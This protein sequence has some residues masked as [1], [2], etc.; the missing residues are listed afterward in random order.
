MPRVFLCDFDGTVAP[1]DIGAAFARAFSPGGLAETPEFLAAWTRGEMGHRELT[2]A[3]C[4]LLDVDRERALAFTRGFGI[5]PDF[6]VFVHAARARGD[7]VTVVSEGFDFY[8]G[9][10]LE[11]AGL[12][13]VSFSANT[14]R[15]DGARV[16]PEFPD[17]GCGDCGNC[18]GRHVREWRAR[19]F[20]T[21]LVG[22]GL[23]DRCGA[24]EADQVYARRDL[25]AWC[26]REGREAT[27][28]E[29]FADLARAI[30]H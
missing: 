12:E 15:F 26:R 2:R 6:A 14:L 22:D 21:V 24:R 4:A 9:D 11:R 16:T 27:P 20:T 10:Q 28:F 25:L 29:N 19:G 1:S 7:E 30:W 3:Q 17:G 8:V 23:S 13:D 5:D 18:K